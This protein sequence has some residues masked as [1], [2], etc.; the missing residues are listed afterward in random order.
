MITEQIRSKEVRTVKLKPMPFAPAAA[1]KFRN[2]LDLD[3][4]VVA[5]GNSVVI[6][7]AAPTAP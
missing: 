5:E 2:E 4:E 6:R 3:L 1:F 7:R